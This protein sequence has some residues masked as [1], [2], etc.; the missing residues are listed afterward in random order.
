MVNAASAARGV[1]A[2]RRRR[3]SAL[4]ASTDRG[5]PSWR[6]WP[7]SSSCNVGT[8]DGYVERTVWDGDQVL[9]ELR[10]NGGD[11][12][13]AAQLDALTSGGVLWGKAGYVHAGGIDKPIVTMDGRVPSYDWRG[14]AESSTW[15][16]G[17]KADCSL[18]FSGCV[19]IAWS[20]G[21]TVY[22]KPS[23]YGT[24]SGGSTPQWAGTVLVDGAGSTRMLYRRNRYDD[25]GP[26]QCTQ[27][28]PIGIAGGANV[29]G[30]AGGDPVNFDDPFGLSSCAKD[31]ANRRLAQKNAGAP[32]SPPAPPRCHP[33]RSTASEKRSPTPADRRTAPRGST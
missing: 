31:L 9:S 26:G 24:P 6:R 14:L 4:R 19:T 28:D 5:G 10:A 18:V 16:D 12:P 22:Y 8:C 13:T 17:A 2:P 32:I 29:Y 7:T 3:S 1:N 25:P 27:Q 33:A 11:S 30:F 23:P 20:S 15:T 21:N